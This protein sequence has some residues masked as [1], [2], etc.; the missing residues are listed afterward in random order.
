M[1]SSGAME[2]EVLVAGAG[3]A[4]VA[5]AVAAART[6]CRVVLIE[7]E[8]SVGGIGTRGMLRT[9]CG[10]YLNGPAEP[11]ETLNEGIPREV[12]ARLRTQAPHRTITRIGNV[13]VLPYNSA[14]LGQVLDSLCRREP[15]VTLLSGARAVSVAVDGGAVTEVVARQ[16]AVRKTIRL[17]AL[18]D[19]TGNG[20]AAIQA[21]AGSELAEPDELQL[22]GCMVRVRGLRNADE[23]LPLK[24]PFVLAEAVKRGDIAPTMRFTTFS[25]GDEPGDGYLKFS[26]E[27]TDG[28]DR[29]M[30]TREATEAAVGILAERLE[31]FRGAVIAE[32]SRVLDREGR[33]IIGEYVLTGE[34][35][36]A[37]RKFPDGVVR[38]AW[39]I[40]LWERKK[41]TV[42]R[43]VPPG[44]Y[45]EIP[46]RC[47]T[48]KGF[49][50]LLVAG[51]CIS[52]THE[53]LGSTRVMG[54]CMA[55]GDQAGRAAAALVQN[56]RYP[57]QQDKREG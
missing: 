24:V 56:G 35:V 46:F 28:E 47:L 36:L 13:F 44:D 2:C 7:R 55:L 40:E 49:S 17:R 8:E 14:E 38:N 32:T 25:S 29:E 26:V 19:C 48:V 23:S 31:P 42:Y 16:G 10:L 53:A 45:Y 41:G 39:P 37:A 12:V 57:E 54:P 6:G 50:N 27:G 1:V 30:R 18:V 52:A 3:V 9:I 20:D 33:R 11:A 15:R 4:G 5:A 21:G 51:R 22:A 34:D 43:F